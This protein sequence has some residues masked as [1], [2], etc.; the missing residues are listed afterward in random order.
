MNIG[1]I[2]II[3]LCILHSIL[4][5]G[6]SLGVNAIIFT[7]P[8]LI[9]LFYIF[10][11]NK[12]I[13]NKWG[14]LFFIPIVLLSLHYLFFNNVFDELNVVATIGLY[15]LLYVFTMK[16][17]SNLG[18]LLDQLVRVFLMPIECI[19]TLFKLIIKK[20]SNVFHLSE[21]NKRILKSLIVVIPIVLIVLALLMSAD[22]IFSS[23]FSGFFD[24]FD[25]ISLP[26]IYDR[27]IVFIFLFIYMSLSIY[28]L[29]N[30]Y[31]ESKEVNIKDINIDEYT[32]KLLLTILNII[33]IIFDIIQ[34]RSLLLH[35][36][37]TGIVYS[38][39][40][41]SG[42]FQLM[43][44]SF[45]NIIIILLS[46]NSKKNNY[47]R[48]MSLFM[49]LLTLIIIISSAYRMYMYESQYGYTVLR[50]GVY[51]ILFSEVILFI[52]T[53]MY[54]IKDKFDVLKYYMIICISIYT[55]INFVPVDYVIARRNVDRYYKTEKLDIYYLEDYKYEN[56]GVL[57]EL[58]SKTDDKG[59][60]DNLDRYFKELLLRDDN[61]F[62][63]NVWRDN[64]YKILK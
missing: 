35:R 36:V 12:L 58:Y 38:E 3:I 21:T 64:S 47:S 8:L 7:I 48:N 11:I 34:I 63:Y 22:S 15:G 60:K 49:V 51:T 33:Y 44:I 56:V 29:V 41:R 10:K 40:A 6:N 45:I 26:K 19:D 9:Y 27:L 23:L 59:L 25:D 14:L 61:I 5:F 18:V 17:T 13:K 62:E 53:I 55:I 31:K 32:I 46:K 52:P 57:K 42:F 1:L 20:I 43:F 2:Y 4:F 54:I 30:R 24:L 50:L 39:Y 28:Y 37:S 16:P